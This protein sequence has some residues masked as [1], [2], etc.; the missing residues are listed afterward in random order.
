MTGANLSE[1]LEKYCA[2]PMLEETFYILSKKNCVYR[3]KL[4]EKGLCL[5][6]E[7]NGVVKSEIISI[8]DIIGC[9]C[10]RGKRLSNNCVCRPIQAKFNDPKVVDLKSQDIDENDISAYLY[11]YA[12][13]LKNLK[14]LKSG[15]KREKMTVTLRFRG[16]ERYEDN[17]K[18]AQKW[19]STL[20]TLMVNRKMALSRK[21]SWEEGDG[22]NGPLTNGNMLVMN[23]CDTSDNKILI[24]LNPKSGVGK[25]REF[26]QSRVV[27]ILTDAEIDYDV[28]VTSCPNDAR[29]L[30][31]KADL[32]KWKRGIV[33]LGGDGILYEI[34][35]GLMERPDWL[36][37]LQTI[38]LGIVPCGS[39]NG[40]AKSI[41]HMSQEPHDQNPVLVSTLNIVQG[42]STP[43]DLIRAQTKSQVVF[44]FLSIGWGLLADIDIESERIR[45][46][47]SQ[48]FAIWSMARLI[49][50]R[51]YQGTLSFLRVPEHKLSEHRKRSVVHSMSSQSLN[52]LSPLPSSK[53]FHSD[54]ID[55]ETETPR[56]DCT[57][58]R[59]DSFHSVASVKSSFH[60]TGAGSSY[61]SLH[62][63]GPVTMYGP[64]SVLPPLHQSLPSTWEVV[65]GEFIMVHAAYQSHLAGDCYFSPRSE[66]Y[67]GI[68]WL[69]YIKAGI[70]RN[71][72]F[73][74]LLGLASGSHVKVPGVEMV[75]VQGFR[76]VPHSTG[77]YIVVD[78]EVVEYG[79]I[80]AEIF[81][82]FMNV[83]ATG[84][85]KS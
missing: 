9:R 29:N 81:P 63:V 4:I 48:R 8:D 57:I 69:F 77:S 82:G 2:K 70:S 32:S 83:F 66:L 22:V 23:P 72:L 54:S 27:P 67:D 21:R 18:E 17:M 75:P 31:R 10:M 13:V 20:K 40:L 64:T 71:N 49:G 12:Y 38:T 15:Q 47:G 34:I 11:I 25:A 33:V 36:N 55:L 60:S 74:F 41:S 52:F 3:V 24:V 16:F 6:K 80:Q 51:T 26:F 28:H 62:E 50:L 61:Q 78:G 39:G 59:H 53:S 85:T 46:V 1:D 14:L 76:L 42:V 65:E 44:S 84:D 5:Q 19:K 30:M 79:P 35:N 43:M 45:A 56:T 58:S 7:Y 37:V 68:M 73:H